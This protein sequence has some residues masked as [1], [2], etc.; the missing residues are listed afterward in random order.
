M[1]E[2]DAM[3]EGIK[4]TTLAVQEAIRKGLCEFKYE[5]GTKVEADD[6]VWDESQFP[7]EVMCD[8]KKIMVNRQQVLD[9]YGSNGEKRSQ[10]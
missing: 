8:G 4:V 3:I 1:S 5:D 7:I 6:Y 9:W 10:K 2:I